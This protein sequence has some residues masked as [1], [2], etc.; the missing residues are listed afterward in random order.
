MHRALYLLFNEGYH[1]A[2]SES[3]VRA[4]LCQEA[5]RLMMLLVEQPLAATPATHALA[6]LMYLHAARLPA[7]VN[8][9][10]RLERAGRSGSIACGIERSMAE[11]DDC[12]SCSAA[13]DELTEYHIEAAIAGDHASAP[14]AEDT[15]WRQ[16]VVAL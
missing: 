13:G 11:G 8:A 9:A 10:G 15:D 2:S 6:A 14:R 16:I 5:I 12:S 4:E 3:A 1:G 7:R